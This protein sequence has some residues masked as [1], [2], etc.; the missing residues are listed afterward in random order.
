MEN[1]SNKEFVNRFVDY[2]VAA[3]KFSSDEL[4]K[5]L[6][7]VGKILDVIASDASRVS[8]MPPDTKKAFENMRAQ[9][10]GGNKDTG[11]ASTGGLVK[12]IAELRGLGAADTSIGTLIFPIVASLQFHEKVRHHLTN[13]SRMTEC[14]RSW[15]ETQT[16]GNDTLLEFGKAISALA[17]TQEERALIRSVIAGLPQEESQDD[18][19]LF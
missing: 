3:L 11:S 10:A 12:V 14:W 1:L 16:K 4:E 15:D 5:S 19:V 9:L 8:A 2:T 13:L 17:T 7:V 6:L 18:V